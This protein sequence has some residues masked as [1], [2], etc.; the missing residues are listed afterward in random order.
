MA[1]TVVSVTVTTS[2]YTVPAGTVAKV[3]VNK[4]VNSTGVVGSIT[5][6]QYNRSLAGNDDTKDGSAG[7]GGHILADGT[8]IV[9]EHYLIAGQTIFTSAASVSV[10][11][12]V[13]LEDI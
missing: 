8:N 6:G 11:A 3:I 5:I 4:V 2:A 12:T 1:L 13:F 9:R 7:S 10:G